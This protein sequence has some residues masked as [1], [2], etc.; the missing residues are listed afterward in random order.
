MLSTKL[1]ALK[2]QISPRALLCLAIVWAAV[3]YWPGLHSGFILDDGPNLRGIT[4]MDRGGEYFWGY[5]LG[6]QSGLLGRTVSMFSF[7]LNY[8][9]FQSLD[10]FSF[11]LV[12]LLIHGLNAVLVYG[13]CAAVIRQC[14]SDSDSDSGSGSGFDGRWLALLVAV[15]WLF[16]PL[17]TSLVLH[18]IQRMVAPSKRL[19]PAA[20]IGPH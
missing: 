9:V 10:P 8:L 3:I 5:V 19:L 4:D 11:K 1:G 16:T 20:V 12:N 15:L 13:F 6:N 17:H 7:A 14:G 18:V 2:Q